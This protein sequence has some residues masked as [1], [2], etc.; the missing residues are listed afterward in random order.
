V[1]VDSSF[2][3]T[4]VSSLPGAGLNM[5]ARSIES[6]LRATSDEKQLYPANR[7]PGASSSYQALEKLVEQ[8]AAFQ[9]SK[10]SKSY[11]TARERLEVGPT[12]CSPAYHP[13]LVSN[14][15]HTF[16]ST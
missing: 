5:K 6:H 9:H 4:D 3:L 2:W 7:L 1:A 12:M 10:D 13:K 14:R 11:S 8:L 15:M 16:H